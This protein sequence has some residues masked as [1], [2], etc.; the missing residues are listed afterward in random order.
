MKRLK[1]KNDNLDEYLAAFETLG[2]HAEIDPNNPSNLWTFAL[3]LLWL[4]ADACIKMENPESYK[5][6]RAMVQHQQK[7]YLKTKALHSEYGTP[8]SNR[9]QGQGQRQTS[10][11]IWCRPGGNNSGTNNQNWCRPGNHAQPPQPH[12]PPQD[13]NT[14]DTSAVICKATNDKEHEEYYKTGRCFECRKQGHL[15]CDCPNKKAHTCT[16]CTVQI[17]DDDKS[18]ISNSPPTT[19]SLT[20]QVA[21]LS[22]EDRVAFMDEICSLGEDM[23]FQATWV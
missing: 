16:T 9:A 5:Q 1:M 3:G 23:D 22:E 10:G 17:E 20:V 18:V 7:I 2:L 11:W 8:S 4:L 14:I 12:L 6:W 19:M 21:C 13:D 15:I